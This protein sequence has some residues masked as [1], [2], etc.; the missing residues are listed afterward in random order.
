M[1]ILFKRAKSDVNAL[2]SATLA[3]MNVLAKRAKRLLPDFNNNC[4]IMLSLYVVKF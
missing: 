3:K 1:Y 2:F 4:N